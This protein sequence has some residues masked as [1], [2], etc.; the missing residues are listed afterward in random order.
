MVG[1][2]PRS[3]L[4]PTLDI[5]FRMLFSSAEGRDSLRALLTAVLRPKV[6]ITNVE[7][8]NPELPRE[9]VGA[10]GVILD[11]LVS[12]GDG[13][14]IDVEMQ[15]DKRAA[16]RERIV[17]YW[18][19]DFG[20]QLV[21]GEDFSAL[22]PVISVLF[23]DYVELPGSRWHSTYRLREEE[24][25]S[26]LTDVMELHIIELPKRNG[27]TRQED[28]ALLPWIRF[29]GAK[30]DEEV[31]EACMGSQDVAKANEHLRRLSASPRARDLAREREEALALYRIEIATTRD[32]AK[33]E[34]KAE[35]KAEAL[36]RILKRRFGPA[37]AEVHDRVLRAGEEDVD[38][39]L[40]R[41][42]DATSVDDVFRPPHAA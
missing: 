19:K 33:A 18:A 32:E 41:A 12:F 37:Q 42:I 16:F 13:R 25:H 26:A 35:G 39:W 14:R 21:R 1:K 3:T 28:A 22:R 38:R 7:I 5:V 27:P 4:D 8:L 11:L 40:D 30:T 34:G 36:L 10:R 31:K 29:L 2:S 24:D 6:P 23:L 15:A 9:H 20:G 17:Y